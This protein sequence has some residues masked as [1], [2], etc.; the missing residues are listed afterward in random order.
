MKLTRKQRDLA[1]KTK[2]K[3]IKIKDNEY[4]TELDH[5]NADSLLMELLEGLGF[6]D[7]VKEYDE[8]DKWYA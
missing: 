7:I 6:K 1:E 4:D 5:I 2:V 3:L 8:I